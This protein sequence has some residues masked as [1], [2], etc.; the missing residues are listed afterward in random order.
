MIGSRAKVA[1][2]LE[3]LGA[4]GASPAW[5]SGVHAPIGLAI[6]AVTPEEIAISIVAELVAVR[7]GVPADRAGRPMAERPAPQE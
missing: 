5:L 6:G 3:A 2:I 1:R 4:G 7:R